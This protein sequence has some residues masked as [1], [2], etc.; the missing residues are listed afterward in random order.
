METHRPYYPQYSY[1]REVIVGL[2]R[3]ILLNRPRSFREDARAAIAQLDPPLNLLGAENLPRAG[4]CVLTVNHYFRP[5][6]NAWWFALALSA[7]LP[8][9]IHWIMT[10]EL[11]FPHKWYAP[12]GMAV[13]RLILK[14]I[15]HTYGFTTMPPM[16]PRPGDVEARAASIR[17]VLEHSRSD[18]DLILGLAPEG[19]DQPGGL[20]TLPTSGA[21]RFALLL[22]A[23]GRKFVPVGAFEADG[24]FCLH[25]GQAYDLEIQE[26]LSSEAKD[27]TAARIMMNKIAPLIPA[28]LRGEFA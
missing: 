12:V 9:N 13:S 17:A 10:G 16:P 4:A 14:K 21:G 15:A 19:G 8:G 27:Q 3:D 28:P 5:G 2:V 26:R 6:F 1:P 23:S 25:F 24:R 20:L 22:A 11:T 7:V 18:P